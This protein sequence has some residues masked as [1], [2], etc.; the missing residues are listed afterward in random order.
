MLSTHLQLV[1]ERS[2]SK[3]FQFLLTEFTV[4]SGSQ[5]TDILAFLLATGSGLAS[6]SWRCSQVFASGPLHSQFTQSRTF[7]IVLQI[8]DSVHF[9]LSFLSVF[10]RLL[11]FYWSAFNLLTLLYFHSAMREREREGGRGRRRGGE[12]ENIRIYRDFP[13][14]SLKLKKTYFPVSSGQKDK[15]LLHVPNGEFCDKGHFHF[16]VKRVKRT[17]I[18]KTHSCVHHFKF[19][20]PH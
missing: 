2:T 7:D 14:Q 5:K 19:W 8:P 12:R 1:R 15:F 9:V 20:L 6:V 10:L 4:C 18:W 13:L 16:K 3:L 11:N 17:K